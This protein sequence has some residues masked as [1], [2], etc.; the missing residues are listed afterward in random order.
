MNGIK[1]LEVKSGKYDNGQ[2]A[3]ALMSDHDFYFVFAAGDDKTDKSLFKELPDS[4]Y[5]IQVGLSPSFE[6]YND[7][8][9]S[10]LLKMM[11]E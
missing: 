3:I 7:T 6:K 1:Y 8:D 5:T 4:V 10:E 11:T 9:N 2:T